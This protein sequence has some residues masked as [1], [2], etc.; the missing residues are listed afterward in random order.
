V[1]IK[2]EQAAVEVLSTLKTGLPQVSVL[3]PGFR[4]ETQIPPENE[5]K[6][7]GFSRKAA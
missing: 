6:I 1:Q 3:R 2:V 7:A 4:H 5:Q